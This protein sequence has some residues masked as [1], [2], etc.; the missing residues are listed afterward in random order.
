MR[1]LPCWQSRTCRRYKG[2]VEIQIRDFDQTVIGNPSHDLIR[3]GLSL[4]MASR[5]SD[6]P[7]VTT[8]KMLEQMISG[9]ERVAPNISGAALQLLR[10]DSRS[11]RSPARAADST[12][13]S[14]C[15][16][17]IGTDRREPRLRLRK[18]YPLS[19]ACP[20][21]VEPMEVP[22]DRGVAFAA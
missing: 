4:A 6:L 2:R 3:L 17:S 8:A 5:G 13:R 20:D 9:T 7:G 12:P 15:A 18:V 10:P 1:R 22:I 21:R 16:R 11:S 14:T 19:Q